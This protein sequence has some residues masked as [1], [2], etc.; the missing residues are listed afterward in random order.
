MDIAATQA[1]VDSYIQAQEDKSLLRFITCGSVDDGKSTLIGRLLYESKLL[2]EDQIAALKADSIRSGTQGDD[3]DFALLVDGLASER[4]QGITIDVAYR[5]FSTEARK[6]I[7]IDTPGHEQYTRNMATGASQAQLAVLLV[8]A[9]LGLSTQTKRHSYIVNALGVK[10]IVVA[11]NKMDLVGYSQ[12]RYEEIIASY[13]EFADKIGI[14]DFT[15]IPVSALK[16]DNVIE[17]SAA[18]PWYQGDTLIAHLNTVPIGETANAQPFRMHVQWVNRPHLDFRGFSGRVASGQVHV[19]DKITA[20]PSG[21]QSRV[22]KI[23]IMDGELD[24]ALPGESVTICLTDEID[25]SRGDLLCSSANA[26]AL[27]DR[28]ESR[29]LW[30]SEEALRPGQSYLMKIGAQTINATI[31][32]P[33][34]AIDVN[35]LA[36]ISAKTLNLNEIGVSIVNIEK[37]IPFEPYTLN[38]EMGSFI[39]INRLTNATVAMGLIEKDA[40]TTSIELRTDELSIDRGLRSEQKHQKPVTLWFT[41]LKWSGKTFIANALERRLFANG[42]HSFLLDA[43]TMWKGLSEDLDYVDADRTENSRRVAQVCK[44]MNDAGLIVQSCFTSAYT[45]ERRMSRKIIGDDSFI[46]IHVNTPLELS[47]AHDTTGFYKKA[48]RGE[49]LNIAG[50]D[51]PYE[52]PENPDIV[53]GSQTHSYEEAAQLIFDELVN[54]GL[55]TKLG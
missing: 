10:R 44:L 47:E 17:K 52:A 41:G 32:P 45:S 51:L 9:R 54:R 39:L 20:L 30:M 24:M 5:F 21:K 49:I 43:N 11:I 42:N 37:P 48:R 50:I 33:K 3:L 28:F 7:V 25:V 13:R 23:V 29:L 40:Q 6:F 27:S 34:Y 15:A 22:A 14:A 31:S 19:G 38:K 55:I 46:E 53:V 12:E 35:T 16:G 1:S 4:E 26:P 2:F 8:D 36:H 18:M